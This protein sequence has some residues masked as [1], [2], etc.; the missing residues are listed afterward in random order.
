MRLLSASNGGSGLPAT[1]SDLRAQMEAPRYDPVLLWAIL[2]LTAVGLASVYSASAVMSA[3]DYG[4]PWHFLV[5]Q[6]IA[7]GVGLAGMYGAMRYGYKRL[8]KLAYPILAITAVALLLVLVPGIGTVV[9]G[10]RRWIRFFGFNFQPAE[11]AKFALVIYL[12]RSLARKGE[13]VRSFSIGFLPHVLVTGFFMLL[14]LGQPDFGSSMVLLVLLWVMLFCAGVQLRWLV[15]SAFAA[16]P[17]AAVLVLSKEYRMARLTAFMDPWADRL[18]NGWQLANSLLTLGNG[19]VTGQGIGA[20]KQKL[21]YLPEG[22]TDF[23]VSVIGE[24]AGLLGIAFVVGLFGLLVWRGIR[25]AFNAADAFGAYLALGL[26]ALLGIQA[27]TNMLVA[28]GMLPTKGLT[29][30]FVS[31]GGTSLVLSLTAAGVLL[32]I[33]SGSGGYLRP[34]SSR[35]R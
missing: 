26:T 1:S 23:I 25:A 29:L 8:E 11:L 35:S 32:A 22:H 33:S 20:G 7:A 18:G 5:R 2:G 24:E 9:N 31:Y 6:S 28:M 34:M 19:G 4:S 12:A 21:H 16:A 30:P 15:G 27:V 14:L 13:K 10:A 17:L 3:R